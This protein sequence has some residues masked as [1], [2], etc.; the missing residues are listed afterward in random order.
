[1]YAGLTAEEREALAEVT[2]MGFPPR[3][4]F[5]AARIATSYASVWSMLGD[6]VIEYDPTYLDDFWTVP[7][8]LGA[9]PTASLAR[10]RIQHKT[11]V[12]KPIRAD[13][14]SALGIGT[15]TTIFRSKAMSDVPV[16]LQ[17]ADVPQAGLMGSMLSITTGDAA[18][19]NFWIVTSRDDIVMTGQGEEHFAALAGIAGGDNVVIDNSVYLAVQT[20][21]RHQV[22]PGFRVWDQFCVNG[23]PVYP[24]RPQ[25]IGRRFALGG[26]GSLQSGRFSGK[27][28]VVA[29]LM[30]EAAYPWQAAWYDD[31]V[32]R[33][34]GAGAD[35]RF[36]IWFVDH[37]MHLTPSVV[38][39][40]PRPVRTTRIVSYG[41]VLQQALRELVAW[42]ERGQPPPAS[43]TYDVVD[44]QVVLPGNASE[45]KGLQ[46][47]VGLTVNGA[48]RADV[49]VGEE[50]GFAALIEVPPGTGTIVKVEWDFD[51]SG[52]FAVTDTSVDGS[53]SRLHVRMT[54]AFTEPGIYFPA[55]RVSAQRH[56]NTKKTHGCAQN[57]GRVR[58]VVA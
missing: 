24:Q 29:S 10:A 39:N 54:Y 9:D 33:A 27:V 23:T 2:R 56:G 36:R 3:A 14:A 32:H 7:G 53:S 50:A 11:S 57:L 17:L 8:Y 52:E 51:G 21:Y 55:L 45:R 1:M 35:D 37:A 6:K 12:V 15:G 16:A 58:V 18:G 20:Y 25:L 40:D 49:A 26:A 44:G 13:E 4:W 48:A 46:P 41:G 38:P 31:L 47:T 43:T 30:D 22:D 34:Q 42:V 19:H 28:I 5:D